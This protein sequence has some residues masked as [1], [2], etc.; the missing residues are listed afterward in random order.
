VLKL[1]KILSFRNIGLFLIKYEFFEI[2]NFTRKYTLVGNA[3][4]TNIQFLVKFQISKIH[5]VPDIKLIFLKLWIFTNCD[6]V[7][8][9]VVSVFDFEEFSEELS[10]IGRRSECG[11]TET[12]TESW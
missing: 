10:G 5:N 8:P 7:F 1:V 4:P 9:V 6:T 11:P 3:L 2:R 12:L